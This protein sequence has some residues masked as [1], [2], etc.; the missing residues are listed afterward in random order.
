MRTVIHFIL[1]TYVRNVVYG[2]LCVLCA[3][4]Y[5]Y[6]FFSHII[7]YCAVLCK[8]NVILPLVVY[9]LRVLNGAHSCNLLVSNGWAMCVNCVLVSIQYHKKIL[10][11]F[12][13]ISTNLNDIITPSYQIAF[14][15]F[16]EV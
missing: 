6:V 3:D 5:I 8:K 9:S 10:E 11:V 14:Y 13:R 4:T 1:C 16:I 15:M 7:L 12:L 2:E